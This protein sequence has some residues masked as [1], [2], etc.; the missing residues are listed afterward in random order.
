MIE[1]SS[2]LIMSTYLDRLPREVRNL[3]YNMRAFR[4][5]RLAGAARLKHLTHEIRSRRDKV[6]RKNKGGPG[7]WRPSTTKSHRDVRKSH[8]N[9]WARRL[10]DKIRDRQ[11]HTRSCR[12]GC[13]WCLEWRSR[14][15]GLVVEWDLPAHRERLATRA[16]T[17]LPIHSFTEVQTWLTPLD[18]RIR[19][20]IL[21]AGRS[22]T[23][24]VPTVVTVDGGL[25]PTV[26]PGFLLMN[27]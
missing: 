23:Y 24:A 26:R 21:S 19:W 20:F 17:V 22:Y 27:G 25:P 4:D 10:V 16:L 3:I 15:F 6:V 9:Q 14:K 12:T 8:K 13:L 11:N 2:D 5:A 18:Q 7:C 1:K